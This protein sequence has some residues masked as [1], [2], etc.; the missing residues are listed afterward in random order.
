MFPVSKECCETK[1]HSL[2]SEGPQQGP[3]ADLSP[4]LSISRQAVVLVTVVPAPR[5]PPNRGAEDR[6]LKRLFLAAFIVMVLLHQLDL[7]TCGFLDSP[8]SF[9]LSIQAL[10]QESWLRTFPIL[11]IIFPDL[12]P[13][14]HQQLRK[15]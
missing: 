5:I 8:A 4:V 13:L 12:V 15:V 6:S 3:S 9:H 14:H 10:T 1:Q 7:D 11:Q 2:L